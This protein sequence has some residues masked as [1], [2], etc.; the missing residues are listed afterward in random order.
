MNVN[1]DGGFFNNNTANGLHSFIKQRY[2][3]YRGVAT[4]YLNR[5]NVLLSNAYRNNSGLVDRIYNLLR[6]N[7]AQ[8]HHSVND[9]IT[10][11]LLGL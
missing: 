11:N 6:S 1:E 2:N 8:R 5:Y 7:D 3:Q 4:K 10:L 9:V